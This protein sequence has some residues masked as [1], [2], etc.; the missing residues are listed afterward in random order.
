MNILVINGGSSTFKFSLY[1]FEGTSFPRGSN[2]LWK[3]T[4]EFHGTADDRQAAIKE[5]LSEIPGHVDII[6]HRIV[7]GGI[8]FPKPVLVTSQ[9]KDI[10]RKLCP[11]A[12]LHNPV[13]LE[14]IELCETIFPEIPQVAVF[15]TAFHSTLPEV[16]WTYAVPWEWREEGIR[17]FGFHGISHQYCSE[18]VAEILKSVPEKMINCHLGNGCSCTAIAN[19]VSIDTSMGFTP[20]EGLMMGTRSGSID[21]GIILYLQ[22]EKGWTEEQMDRCLNKESGLLGIGGDFD[23]R[24]IMEKIANND[25]RA[26]LALDLFVYRL[27]K[28]IGELSAVLGG[29][30]LLSF[31]AGIG[32]NS[33][34]VRKKVCEG[35]KYLGVEIDEQK[36][37]IEDSEISTANSKVKVFVIHTCED[38]QIA[39]DCIDFL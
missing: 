37:C 32:E 22:K 31:T 10:I 13:N 2:P 18:T 1:K 35:L 33:P 4:I 23:M 16:A 39:K 36:P 20:L 5:T 11:L 24:K 34:E 3:K 29:L 15:D 9:V 7:H 26:I 27:K 21:P 38:W 6:G 25:P 12:P 28:V 30:D 14:G 8:H 19:G 17:R